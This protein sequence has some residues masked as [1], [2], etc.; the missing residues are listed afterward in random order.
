MST[1][2]ILLIVIAMLILAH[3]W[4]HFYVARRLGVRVEE[5]G[6][7][8]PPRVYSWVNKGVRYSINALPLGGFVKIFG[9]HG[10]GAHTQA[11]FSGRPAL[12]RFMILAAGVF[13]NA[14]MA[15][16]F[17][18]AG[19]AIGV[20][21]VIEEGS[22]GVRVSVIGVM[23]NS[24]AE[25]AGVRFGDV[26]LEARS[27]DI[28]LRIETEKDI[29]DFAQAYRGED[30][31]LVI[32]RGEEI[33]EL[34]ATPRVNSPEGEG[35]LGIGLGR[36]A[37]DRSPWYMAPWDGLV[38][39][40]RSAWVTIAGFL[41][42]FQQ[43]FLHGKTSVPVSGPVGIF[44]FA[45]DSQTLGIAYFLQFIGMLSVNLAVLNFL[46]IPALDGGR[47]LFLIIEKIRRR[48]VDPKIENMAHMVGFALLILLMVLVTYKDI[49]RLL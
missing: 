4:G 49:A 23:P 27:R 14:L 3:E 40:G 13:M 37:V 46:P 17:F 39:L 5:F 35:P 7:G 21:H 33:K 11:S 25:K 29:Q 28:T 38:M 26:L 48:R 1:F 41:F 6:I 9:E 36:L 24:P 31:T 30:V 22:T 44:F 34:H 19:A 2:L 16:I 45:K 12:Q 15:W 32:K 20:P 18:T 47:V 8:F 43:I 42:I 10:E